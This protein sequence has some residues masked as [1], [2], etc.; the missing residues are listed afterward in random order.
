MGSE[1]PFP[2]LG[3]GIVGKKHGGHSVGHYSCILQLFVVGP[4]VVQVQF[5][6]LG[7]LPGVDGSIL[8]RDAAEDQYIQQ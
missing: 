2:N 6:L 8:A 1:L 7:L 3:I 4:D 5:I